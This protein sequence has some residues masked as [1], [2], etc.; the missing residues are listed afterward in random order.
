[1]ALGEYARAQE[2]LE[3]SL[4][5]LRRAGNPYRIAMALNFYGDL[6]R[7]QQEYR[8]AKAAYEESISL[9]REIAAVRD[10]ASVL[11]NLGYTCLH[12]GDPVEPGR[13]SL[14]ASRCK[15]RR[16]IAAAQRSP[17][18]ASPPWQCRMAISPPAGG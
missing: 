10:Q 13:T 14:R 1:M 16:R 8:A 15:W 18:W 12:L 5:L 17:W 3:E 7:C 9:L 4:P 11:H 2:M 6:K